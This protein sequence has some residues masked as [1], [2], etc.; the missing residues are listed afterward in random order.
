MRLYVQDGDR[1]AGA[2]EIWVLFQFDS[3]SVEILAVNFVEGRN[4]LD[5]ES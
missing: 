4:D 3:E 2:P 1:V 5:E